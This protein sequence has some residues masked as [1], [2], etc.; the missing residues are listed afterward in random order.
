MELRTLRYFVTVAEELN[1][2]RAAKIL[3]ISQPPL[4][5]Q[6]RSLETEL[7]T[8][9]FIRGKRRLELTDSGQLLYRRAKEILNLT[10]KARSEI[11][12]MKEGMKG[13]ISIGLVEGMASEITAGW[14]SD[15]RKTH[16]LAT[17]R[18]LSGNSDEL[19]EKL[20]S[21]LISLA[22][23]TSPYDQLLLNSFGIGSEK[24]VAL[25]NADNPLAADL[26]KPIGINEMADCPL[27]VPSRKS[28]I[29]L[30][31][32]WFRKAGC[33]PTI[34]CE[35]DSFADAAS[36]VSKDAGIGLFP[37][38]GYTTPPMVVS[39]D[40]AVDNRSVDY[41]FVWRKGHPLPSIEE[42]FIDF[43]KERV[44]DIS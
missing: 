21:G 37:Q 8:Q 25:I 39:R 13:T 14:I 4:S 16:P 3:N 41:L 5:M 32:K 19:T 15:F 7:E 35:M 30:I 29:D 33:Q 26:N 1:I 18:I 38:T 23:I 24:M 9:L 36:L 20:R 44:I 28:N 40:I 10:D 11:I 22:V 42:A 31:Y 12:S 2:T 6:I 43:I 34:I 27:I 17:F